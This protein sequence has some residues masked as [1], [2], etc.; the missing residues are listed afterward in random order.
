MMLPPAMAVARRNHSGVQLSTL[1]V[2]DCTSDKD[3]AWPGSG[4]E[5]GVW[6]QDFLRTSTENNGT[7]CRSEM[8]A[9]VHTHS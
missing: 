4:R 6:L 8:S 9:D 1:T 7:S 2:L 3:I 5:G